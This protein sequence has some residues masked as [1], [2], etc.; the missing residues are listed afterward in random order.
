MAIEPNN[1]VLRYIR[2]IFNEGVGAEFTDHQLLERFVYRPSRDD[3]AELAFAALVERHGPM[4]LRVCRAALRDEHDAQ[5]AFQAVFLVLVHKARLLRV[6]DSLGPWLHAVALRVSTHARALAIKRRVHERKS[7]EMS[8]RSERVMGEVRD[9]LDSA[10]CWAIALSPDGRHVA[11]AQQDG[12]TLI[13]RLPD[14][15]DR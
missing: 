14:G 15:T 9:E 3:S 5:D 10:P 11:A 2:A 13:Y 6:R 8:T 4:V 1:S 7:A 12:V